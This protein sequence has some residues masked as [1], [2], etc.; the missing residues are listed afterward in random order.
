MPDI[1]AENANKDTPGWRVP[2]C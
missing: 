1:Q 2:A